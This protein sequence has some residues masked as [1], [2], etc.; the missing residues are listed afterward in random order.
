MTTSQQIIEA[1]NGKNWF[2]A[3]EIIENLSLDINLI[4]N[5]PFCKI[6]EVKNDKEITHVTITKRCHP[7]NHMQDVTFCYNE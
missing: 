2:E 5:L 1:V 3:N 7:Y 6:W 4:Q